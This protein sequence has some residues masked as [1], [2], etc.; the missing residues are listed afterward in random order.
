MSICQHHL[1]ISLRN[2]QLVVDEV[3]LDDRPLELVSCF[4]GFGTHFFNKK[5]SHGR[6][7]SS[8]A[9]KHLIST[10]TQLAFLFLDEHLRLAYL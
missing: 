9:V 6:C 2:E 8:L 10:T 7:V 5:G 4:E 3:P 1:V